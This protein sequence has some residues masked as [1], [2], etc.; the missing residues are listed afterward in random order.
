MLVA[1]LHFVPD[2]DDPRRIV[3]RLVDAM[4]AGSYVVLSH[5]TFDPLDAATVARLN[6]ANQ[7]TD[8]P[9]CPRGRGE[10]AGFLD[11]L[12]LVEPGIVSVSDWHAGP[13]PRPGPAEAAGYAAVARKP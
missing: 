13:G 4:P 2:S 5:A 10:I 3:A 8:P 6:A 1:L 9:F 12:E 7:D 11:G